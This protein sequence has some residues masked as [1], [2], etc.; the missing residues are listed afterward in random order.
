VC[1]SVRSCARTS[2]QAIQGVS[3]I[4]RIQD[5]ADWGNWVAVSQG[6]IELRLLRQILAEV[7]RRLIVGAPCEDCRD[8]AAVCLVVAG[9]AEPG[10]G[11]FGDGVIERSSD[12]LYAFGVHA[13]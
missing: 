10:V 13:G 2:S 3:R 6:V 11:C 9:V 5:V 8:K 1:R 4:T 7:Q 12:L